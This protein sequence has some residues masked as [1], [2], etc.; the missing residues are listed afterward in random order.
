MASRRL[1]PADIA[2]CGYARAARLTVAALPALTALAFWPGGLDA[3]NGPKLALFLLGAMVLAGLATL[4][5]VREHRFTIPWAAWSP[6]VVLFAV[7]VAAATVVSAEPARS[8]AGASGARTGLALYLSCAVIAIA[9]AT[10]FRADT[11]HLAVRALLASAVPVVMYAGVQ[12]RGADPLAWRTQPGAQIF[13]TL[14]NSNFMSA[15]LGI[16]VVLAV[17]GAMTRTWS[18]AWRGASGALAATGFGLAVVS[19]SVQG[20]LACVAGTVLL[21]MTARRRRTMVRSR[22][23]FALAASGIGIAVAGWLAATAQIAPTLQSRIWQWQAA[24][25]MAA[26]RPLLGVGLDLYGDWYHAYRP[27]EDAVSRGLQRYADSAHSVPLHLLA[28]G[29]VLVLT[30]YLGVIALTGAALVKGLRRLDGE[31][32]LLLAGLGGAW[33]AYQ[34]ASLV[35]IDV[36]PLAALHWAL[37]GL[38]VAVATPDA[39]V[40]LSA[41][42]HQSWSPASATGATVVAGLAVLVWL[43][44][45]RAEVSA[46]RSLHYAEAGRRV[47]ADLALERAAQLAPWDPRYLGTLARRQADRDHWTQAL[48]TLD[49]ARIVHQRHLGSTL[50]RARLSHRSGRIEDAAAAYREALT[51]DPSD[52][53]LLVEVARHRLQWAQPGEAVVLLEQAIALDDRELWRDLLVRARRAD[54]FRSVAWVRASRGPRRR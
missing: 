9:T 25:K 17:W 23:S 53:E 24:L 21:L 50:L 16:V 2:A 49:R 28:G 13:S 46:T 1:P 44:P 12:W 7:A 4:A 37:L 42:R 10:V 5:S 30:A 8:A 51:L 3:F 15:W 45:I 32:R 40:R 34:V 14:G 36:T 18:P 6:S 33:M 31:P 26:D 48:H 47:E 27:V 20:P 35:S 38:I 41:C 43:V 22:A 52:P 39:A 54:R 19:G 29:G 11:A